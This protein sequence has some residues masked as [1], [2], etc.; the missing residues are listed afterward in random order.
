MHVSD[1]DGA[2]VGSG[3]SW[4]AYVDIYVQDEGSGGV[5]DVEI[6]A[7]TNRNEVFSC[8]TGPSGSCQMVF[9]MAARTITLTIDEVVHATLVYSPGDNVDPDG[10]SDGTEITLKAAP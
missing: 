4:T 9:V 3:N 8:T 10:D 7:S 1:I 5:A 2:L 6:S